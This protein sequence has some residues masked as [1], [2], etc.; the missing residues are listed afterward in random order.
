[1][2]GCRRIGVMG[3]ASVAAL[4]LMPAGAQ[5][6]K[7][8]ITASSGPDPQDYIQYSAGRGEANRL[9]VKVSH[10]RYT[11][12]DRGA[13]GIRARSGC[14]SQGRHKAVCK[15]GTVQNV[16]VSLGDGNDRV[17]FSGLGGSSAPTPP[18]TDP[19]QLAH[20]GAE[21]IGGE[22]F[23]AVDVN[24]GPGND[25]IRTTNRPD[26]VDSGPGADTVSTR[27]GDD[28]V[29]TETDGAADT[30]NG[31]PGVDDVTYSAATPVTIDVAAGTGGAAGETD[32]LAN[33]ERWSGGDGD[34]TLKG[35]DGSEGLFGRDGADT[36]DGNGGNDYLAAGFD[37]IPPQADHLSGGAG[38]DIIDGRAKTTGTQPPPAQIQQVSCGD[39][40]DRAFG[41]PDMALDATCEQ[42]IYLPVVRSN[43][44]IPFSTTFPVRP[45]GTTGGNP[46]FR[47]ACPPA[48]PQVP[49]PSRLT[50]SGQVDVEAPVTPGQTTP[51]PSYGTGVFS[52]QPGQQAT[53]TVGLSGAG[54]QALASHTMLGVHVRSTDTLAGGNSGQ[55][56]DFGWQAQLA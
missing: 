32:H 14:R 46:Q 7:V 29:T 40:S 49:D 15:S 39:G 30:I 43:N 22:F 34:D 11:L 4:A 20:V 10:H 28:S 41:T 47:I 55:L 1:M 42:T 26:L 54:Q 24:G 31:G 36:I 17:R 52:I 38:D 51:P 45:I 27:G 19:T 9:T 2:L 56:A 21:L 6:A 12:V 50:C 48:P 44:D 33:F 23:E 18:P 16:S 25:T 53:I 8:S 13:N 37:S 5:A 3:C 35:S